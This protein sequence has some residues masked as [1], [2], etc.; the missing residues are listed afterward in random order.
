M[1]LPR[2]C[3][4]SF[5][6]QPDHSPLAEN[7]QVPSKC[8][9]SQLLGAEHERHGQGREDEYGHP[10]RHPGG[11]HADL[12][13]GQGD[14]IENKEKEADTDA[15]SEEN[16]DTAAAA[17]GAGQ[18]DGNGNE[19]EGGQEQGETLVPPG[20]VDIGRPDTETRILDEI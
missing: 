8:S 20:L 11:N 6:N 7:R 4:D 16:T 1:R 9:T 13:E 3:P 10:G 15:D 17:E 5:E 2:F 18:R 14:A 12:T 19:D